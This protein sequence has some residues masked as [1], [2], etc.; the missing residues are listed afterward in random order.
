M[1]R[2]GRLRVGHRTKELVRRL[3]PGEFAVVDHPDMDLASAHAL[4]ERRVGAVFNLSPSF[5]GRLP[6]PGPTWLIDRGIPVVDGLGSAAPLREGLE[7]ELRGGVVYHRGRPLACGRRLTRSEAARELQ[8]A[9]RALRRQWGVFLDNTLTRAL[10]EK[11]AFLRPL[12]LPPVATRF[13]G[14][15]ALVVVRGGSYR[16]DLRAVLPYVRGVRPALVGVDGGAD[17]LMALGLVPDVVVGDMDSVSDDAL[18]AAREVVVHAYADGHAPG[19]A[20]VEALGLRPLVLRAPGTSEDAAML[21]AYEK[22][23]ELI[24]AVGAHC[25]LEDFLERGR[26]GMAST[27]LVRMLL[28]SRLVDA[29]GAS[30]LYRARVGVSGLV[31]LLA[32]GMLPLAALLAGSPGLR[33]LVRLAVAHLRAVLG[34]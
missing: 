22:G 15:H 2:R 21:L 27:L 6:A 4:A 30:Q 13:R 31:A 17:A 3:R 19:L 1:G 26:P 28:G 33:L 14:R 20:R 16:E 7:V 18:R 24:V 23:A 11:D 25:G 12:S 10:A 29:R 5:S 9:R 8:R 34:G 32:A